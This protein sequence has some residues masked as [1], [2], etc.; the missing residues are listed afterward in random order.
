MVVERRARPYFSVLISDSGRADSKR[1]SGLENNRR[2]ERAPFLLIEKRRVSLSYVFGG[3]G[4]GLAAKF[5]SRFIPF[6]DT[7]LARTRRG[8]TRNSIG[9]PCSAQVCVRTRQP[10]LPSAEFPLSPPPVPRAGRKPWA[11]LEKI[12]ARAV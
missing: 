12:R 7:F 9:T 8:E 10:F 1:A 4:D 5:V 6:R 3:V 11:R 2:R